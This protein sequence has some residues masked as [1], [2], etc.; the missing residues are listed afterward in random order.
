MKTLLLILTLTS[1]AFAGGGYD[2]RSGNTYMTNEYG[3]V[4]QVH[5]YNARTG[6]MWNTTIQQNGDKYGVDAQ[7]NA[8]SYHQNTQ[9]YYNYG[10]GK[11]CTGSGYAQI[12]TE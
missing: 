1:T 7:G 6:S 10:T 9:R 12:C 3:G 5:G 2:W 11:M 4:K 8:W